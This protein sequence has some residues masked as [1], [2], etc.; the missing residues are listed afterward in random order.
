MR[1]LLDTNVLL[2]VLLARE[3]WL[4][5]AAAV[6]RASDDRRIVGYLTASTITDI[7]TSPADWPGW[8]WPKIP[9]ASA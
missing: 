2:D 4:A 7:F 6:W 5:E 3:P 8:R 9:C 1:V